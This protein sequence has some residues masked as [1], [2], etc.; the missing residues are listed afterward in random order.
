MR[1]EQYYSCR[2]RRNSGGYLFDHVD[3]D[4]RF[5]FAD[6]HGDVDRAVGGA[7]SSRKQTPAELRSA[8]GAEPGPT[9]LVPHNLNEFSIFSRSY[10]RPAWPSISRN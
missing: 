5:G 7:R 8:T 2:D 4:V 3:W 1:V 6:Y 9:H 10:F